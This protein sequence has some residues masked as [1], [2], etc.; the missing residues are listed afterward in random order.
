MK[1]AFRGIN[2]KIEV[3]LTFFQEVECNDLF[4]FLTSH[5]KFIVKF[6]TLKS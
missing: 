5:K 4:I 2:H 3:I 6:F 1:L